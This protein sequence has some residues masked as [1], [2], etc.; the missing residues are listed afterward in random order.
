MG[1]L[2]LRLQVSSHLWHRHLWWRSSTEEL[3]LRLV[4]LDTSDLPVHVDLV[5][6][7][8]EEDR[9]L[10]AKWTLFLHK[11]IERFVLQVFTLVFIFLEFLLVQVG[12]VAAAAND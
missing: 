3:S 8:R 6:R 2:H 10:E 12:L 1:L 9:V 11:S 7:A 4:I 5:N